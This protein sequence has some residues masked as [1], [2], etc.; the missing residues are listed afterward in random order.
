MN[1]ILGNELK[2][3]NNSKSGTS[4]KFIKPKKFKFIFLISLFCIFLCIIF[5]FFLQYNSFKKEKI[6]K[7]LVNNF[8]I[9]TLYSNNDNY[10]AQKSSVLTSEENHF[11]I[12]LIKI[13]KINLMYPILSNT[14]EELLEISPCRFCGPMPNEIGN[15]CIAGHNYA[16]Q[17]H[18]GK[19]SSLEEG[20]MIQIYDLNG[21]SLDY[22]IYKK[23]EVSSNDTSCLSQNTNGY[24]E[25]T[26]ITCNSIKGNRLI[27]KAKENI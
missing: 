24:K 4:N 17:K 16:N 13:D 6:S 2:I 9:Q 1:Q 23:Q 8:G 15:L 19:L 11:V 26:L 12:G 7:S 21:T 20:D 27:V 14:T 22:A 3:N 10:I 5:Y 18:F 25:V